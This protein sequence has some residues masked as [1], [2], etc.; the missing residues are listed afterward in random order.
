MKKTKTPKDPKDIP[1][2]S[3][4]RETPAARVGR[5]LVPVGIFPFELKPFDPAGTPAIDATK[6]GTEDLLMNIVGT[7][8][9]SGDGKLV[10]CA[11]VVEALFKREQKISHYILSRTF[12]KG[13]VIAV[14]YPIQISIPYY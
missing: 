2:T 9:Q 3:F 11:H 5:S 8:I 1:W 14:P 7:A 4:G 12:R 10:T 13:A 6:P